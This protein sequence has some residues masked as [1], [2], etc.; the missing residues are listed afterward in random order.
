MRNMSIIGI[1][2][3]I[4]GDDGVGIHAIEKLKEMELP[5]GVE[6]FDAGTDAFYALGAMDG[7]DKTIILDACH[8]NNAPGTLYR[9]TYD[10][11]QGELKQSLRLSMHGLNLIDIMAGAK[12]VYR[13]PG[14]IV[15]LG[16]EPQILEWGTEL[17]APVKDALP[18]LIK[19]VLREV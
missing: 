12:E 6:V 13:L 9:F 7:M 11:L 5:A 14:E 17:S 18:A 1:G 19:M 8:G 4:M 16:V 3:M 15:L 10:Q 2:N